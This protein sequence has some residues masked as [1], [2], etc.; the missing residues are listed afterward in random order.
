MGKTSVDAGSFDQACFLGF[1]CSRTTYVSCC[2]PSTTSHTIP[3]HKLA[4]GSRRAPFH[5]DPGG[6]LTTGCFLSRRKTTLFKSKSRNKNSIEIRALL[7]QSRTPRHRPTPHTVAHDASDPP[8]LKLRQRNRR[9]S[10]Q[11]LSA[12]QKHILMPVLR[13]HP[14]A[15]C[16]VLNN[17]RHDNVRASEICRHAYAQLHPF[18]RIE[19]NPVATTRSIKTSALQHMSHSHQQDPSTMNTLR[20]RTTIQQYTPHTTDETQRSPF[21]LE[22]NSPRA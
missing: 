8:S 19:S 7:A 3:V 20:K 5:C 16:R 18:N 2:H 17:I 13:L 1:S 21:L 4:T 6:P 10:E 15:E 14:T 22:S 9:Q 12:G 11:I